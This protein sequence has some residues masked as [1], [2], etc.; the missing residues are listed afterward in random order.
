MAKV[1]APLAI[2]AAL[3]VTLALAGL[4][5]GSAATK[6]GGG[7]T[8]AKAGVA[9]PRAG[10]VAAP[11]SNPGPAGVPALEPGVAL[12]V[13]TPDPQRVGERLLRSLASASG[14]PGFSSAVR[15]AAAALARA[16]IDVERDLLAPLAAISISLEP[17]CPPPALLACR[18]AIR[19]CGR[20]AER[21]P[22]RLR[23]DLRDAA[24]AGLRAVGFREL[25]ATGS[26]QAAGLAGRVTS[27]EESLARWSLAGG[28]LEVATAGLDLHRC[29]LPRDR[30]AV[31][32]EVQRDPRD[33]A[34]LLAPR[35]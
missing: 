24:L 12:R 10:G 20:L 7:A 29:D 34:L 4:G 27:R 30:R 18:P 3:A 17:S 16:G 31:A 22:E 28:V 2:L 15:R 19:V 32:L 9:A 13:S 1:R 35:P 23:R 8:P 14:S 33:L 11:A 25:A 26:P 21:P 5:D 6:A